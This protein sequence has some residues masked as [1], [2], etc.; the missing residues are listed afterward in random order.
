VLAGAFYP[1]Y[2]AVGRTNAEGELSLEMKAHK[3]IGGHNPYSTVYLKNFPSQRQPGRLYTATI[4]SMFTD[5]CDTEPLVTFSSNRYV[6]KGL[7][8]NLQLKPQQKKLPQTKL[9]KRL[10]Y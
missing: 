1:E 7:N 6:T 4:K 2:Y 5:V 9:K 8:G 10:I 3:E